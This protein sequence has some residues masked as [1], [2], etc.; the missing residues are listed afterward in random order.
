[1]LT[2]PFIVRRTLFVIRKI[3][4]NRRLIN[5]W[6]TVVHQKP[7]KHECINPGWLDAVSTKFRKIVPNICGYSVRNT[8][9][10]TLMAP[11]S[12][13]WLLHIRKCVQPW[14][15]TAQLANKIPPPYTESES[16]PPC[17][18]DGPYSET[19]ASSPHPQLLNGQLNSNLLFT[20]TSCQ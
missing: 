17:L 12:L 15:K 18:T 20:P 8:F 13:R 11:K 1:M 6:I 10:I 19:S 5:F 16:S 9:Q 7:V 4:K 14:Y 3:I 2:S